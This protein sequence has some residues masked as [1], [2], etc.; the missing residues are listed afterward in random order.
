MYQVV[1]RKAQ[2]E[3]R[4]AATAAP[5]PSSELT[6]MSPPWSRTVWRASARPRPR[7]SPFFLPCVMN[8]W[9]SWPRISAAIPGPRVGNLHRDPATLRLCIEG[10]HS[11]APHHMKHD[12]CESLQ[13]EQ[14]LEWILTKQ[15]KRFRTGTHPELRWY[16]RRVWQLVNSFRFSSLLRRLSSVSGRRNPSLRRL[17]IS[18]PALP[19]WFRKTA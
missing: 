16:Q 18:P 8:G 2:I 10:Y 1:A 12:G 14:S 9:K 4:Q 3:C 6:H 11:T 13:P 7:P 15:L 17:R 19:E 5:W